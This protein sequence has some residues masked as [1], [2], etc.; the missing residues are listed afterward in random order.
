ML[1]PTAAFAATHSGH[2]TRWEHS[3]SSSDPDAPTTVTF[4]VTTGLLSITAPAS[5]DFGSTGLSDTSISGSLGTVT[6][7]DDRNVDPANWQASAE[8]T[9]FTGATNP[10]DDVIPADHVSYATNDVTPTDVTLTPA[11]PVDVSFTFA[12]AGVSSDLFSGSASGDNSAT[13]DPT[14]TIGL[15]GAFADDYSGTITNSVVSL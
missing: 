13:W 8:T 3:R 6:I 2:E 5:A 11:A 7:T 10:T 12:G 9:D 15:T 14:I 4:T 1:A